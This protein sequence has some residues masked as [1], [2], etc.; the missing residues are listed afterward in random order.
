[1]EKIDLPEGYEDLFNESGADLD[2]LKNRTSVKIHRFKNTKSY[3]IYSLKD[4][5]KYT[6]NNLKECKQVI[7]DLE[8][9]KNEKNN[10][11]INKLISER[12]ELI[13][14]LRN[15]LRVHKDRLRIT[16]RLFDLAIN[17]HNNFIDLVMNKISKKGKKLKTSNKS[18]F[19][20]YFG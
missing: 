14:K 16:K 17:K 12:K 4:D 15:N 18:E 19:I 3:L 7:R 11:T 5:I 8:V 2:N 1:M 13:S 20:Y 10:D 9:T 6:K